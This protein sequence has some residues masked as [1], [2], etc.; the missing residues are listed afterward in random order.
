MPGYADPGFDTLAIHAGAAPVPATGVLEQRVA[1]LEGGIGAIATASG[2]AAL[3][4]CIATLMGA[5]SHMVAST[6]LCGDAHHL[7]RHTLR[8]FGINTTFVAP[9]DMDAWRAAI[10]PN[11]KLLFG[12]TVGGPALDVLDIP[13]IA[14]IAH[15]AS[16]PLLVD[17][18]RTSPWL[19]Q[20]LALGADLVFHSATP[21][22]CGQGTVM[23]GVVVDGGNFDWVRAYT[24]SG[25]FA[26]L[27]TPCDGFQGMNFGEENTVGAFL[28]R[29]RMEGLCD[30]GACMS[31]GTGERILQGIE[32]LGLRMERH[33]RTTEQ[34]VQFLTNHPLISCVNHPTLPTHHSHA[35]A[36]KVLPKGAGPALSFAL[37]GGHRQSQA[38]VEALRLFSHMSDVGGCRS[39]ALHP[40]STTH[41]RMDD[42]ALAAAGIGQGTIQLRMGLEDA[43]DLVEDLQR[44]LKIAEK[45]RV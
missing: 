39:W 19:M 32:T 14:A 35:L 20:P 44:G 28:L 12:E 37:R 17:S 7:L 9:G 1:A 18:T 33:M 15:E 31:P 22:L 45:V 38:F 11:T 5:G 10:R 40:A 13:T 8:R 3:H 2:P 21:Y 16:V 24:E 23:G 4:L 30:F 34:V 41:A 27:A 25:R 6:A 26:E 43:A 29:A 36:Q 42:A